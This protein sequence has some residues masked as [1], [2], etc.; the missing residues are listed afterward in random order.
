MPAL[1]AILATAL[2]ASQPAPAA[3][4]AKAYSPGDFAELQRIR[5]HLEKPSQ[6][7]RLVNS[8]VVANAMTY[9]D[10]SLDKDEQGTTIAWLLVGPTGDIERCGV[11]VSSG[12]PSLDSKACDILIATAQF[13]PA[14]D[15]SGKGI[16]SVFQQAIRWKIADDPD[17][18]LLAEGRAL[19][20]LKKTISNNRPAKLLNSGEI[21]S[22]MDYPI[23]AL[24]NSEEGEVR[25]LLLVGPDGRVERCGVEASSGFGS[26]DTQTCNLLI[27]HAQFR[28]AEDR[29]GRPVEALYHQKIVWKLQQMNSAA[30]HDVATRTRVIVGADRSLRDCKSEIFIDGTWTHAPEQ[31]CTDL[32]ARDGGLIEDVAAKSRA[33]EPLVVFET[34]NV[35]SA[36]WQIPSVGRR[37]GE[38]LVGLR[39]ASA[40][41][42][43]DGSRTHCAPGES[44]G[45]PDMGEDPCQVGS[46]SFPDHVGPAPRKAERTIRFLTAVY[47]KGEPE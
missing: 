27:A 39:S 13:Y 35:S 33:Y 36:S 32:T 18:G 24:R 9:P 4:A 15:A 2:A 14:K 6:Y 16:P 11:M 21:A 26:L 12:S 25:A 40:S 34:W 20:D 38:V 10:A 3:A 46:T 43:A 44:V 45:F 30:E 5:A 22:A 1:V 28:P 29:R 17:E 47:L 19:A 41:Y 42:A 7:A 23:E 8:D 31:F 37:P